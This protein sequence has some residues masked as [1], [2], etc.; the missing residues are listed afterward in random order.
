[1]FYIPVTLIIT[2]FASLFVAYIIN[3]VFA[4]SFMKHEFEAPDKRKANKRITLYIL[5]S[6]ALAL[7]SYVFYASN[8]SETAF[9]F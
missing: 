3:P 7:V 9:G 6:L 8:H 2:L 4:V 1:M 5:I